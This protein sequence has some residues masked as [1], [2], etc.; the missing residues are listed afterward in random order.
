[1]TGSETAACWQIGSI[2]VTEQVFDRER[3]VLM[4]G[5]LGKPGE[6]VTTTQERSLL[7]A[8]TPKTKSKTQSI[9]QDRL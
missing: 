9:S 1:M 3:S 8:Q 7:T 2:L 4:T 5:M 6:E